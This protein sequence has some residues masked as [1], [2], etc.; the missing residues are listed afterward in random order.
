MPKATFNY[1]SRIGSNLERPS[2]RWT[3]QRSRKRHEAQKKKK[4]INTA[5]MLPSEG[6]A[7]RNIT[8]VARYENDADN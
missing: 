7:V 5:T 3:D 4:N 6:D 2:N 8:D 1:I